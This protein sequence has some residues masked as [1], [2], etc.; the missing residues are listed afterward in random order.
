MTPEA[1]IVAYQS[2]AGL[3]FAL[4]ATYGDELVPSCPGWTLA[5]LAAHVGGAPALWGPVLEAAPGQQPGDVMQ[6]DVPEDRDEMLAWCTIELQSMV[7]LFRTA[8]PAEPAWTGAGT[9]EGRASFWMRRAALE[10]AVHLW[11]AA[12][13]V[14]QEHEIPAELAADGFDELAELFPTLSAWSSK[15][16]QH[17][18]QVAPNDFV[19]TWTYRGARASHPVTT[20]SGPSAEIYLELWGRRPSPPAAARA[21]GD[22]VELIGTLAA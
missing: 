14:G 20:L 4:T 15:E 12:N 2:Q 6:P 10:T 18:L 9:G 17:T 1:W 22:W 3:I 13:A 11:D 8:D 19:R 21:V 16:P 7:E 5:D